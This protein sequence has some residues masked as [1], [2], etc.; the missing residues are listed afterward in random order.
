MR[1]AFFFQVA[2]CCVIM[3]ARKQ[4]FIIIILVQVKYVQCDYNGFVS[5]C[6]W[7]DFLKW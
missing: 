6:S 4:E 5:I 7:Q 2:K 1:T 3:G